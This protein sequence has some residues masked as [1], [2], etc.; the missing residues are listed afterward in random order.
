MAEAEQFSFKAEIQQLL[1]ILV[2]SLYT[3]REIFLRE[4]ISN[5]SDALNRIQFEQLTNANIVDPDA[6]LLIEL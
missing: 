5:A 6:D 4:L 1:N 3:E 2:H